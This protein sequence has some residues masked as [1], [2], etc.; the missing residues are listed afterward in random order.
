MSVE[1]G[2]VVLVST[3]FVCCSSMLC[4]DLCLNSERGVEKE[5]E[6]Y[7]PE[8]SAPIPPEVTREVPQ[9]SE[10]VQPSFTFPSAPILNFN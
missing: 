9:E 10:N 4:C 2:M 3:V 5:N 7:M 8:I 1:A 6:E